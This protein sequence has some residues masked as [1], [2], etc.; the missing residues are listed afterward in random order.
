MLVELAETTI[1]VPG[2]VLGSVSE[3]LKEAGLRVLQHPFSAKHYNLKDGSVVSGRMV[4]VDGLDSCL[5]RTLVR[6]LT[7]HDLV[8]L[9]NPVIIFPF[10]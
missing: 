5:A 6:T 3:E 10:E 2:A 9:N 1:F 4:D 7:A 8:I